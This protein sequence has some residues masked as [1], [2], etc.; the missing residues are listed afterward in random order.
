MRIYPAIRAQMG[1]WSYYMV[2]MKMR[3]IAQEVELAH[4]IYEDKT[5][6]EAIQRALSRTRAHKQIVGYLARRDDRFFSSIVVAAMGGNPKWNPLP[7]DATQVPAVL[8]ESKLLQESFGVLSFDEEPKYYALDGQHRVAAIKLLV[9]GGVGR[10]ANRLVAP[11]TFEND[12]LS[13]LV[14]SREDH[15][16]SDEEWMRRYRRMFS[17]L[18]RY[19]KP[20]DKDTNIIMDEDDLFAILTRRLITD[21]EFFRAPGRER[22]S[23]RVQMEGKNLRLRSPHFTSLQTLYEANRILLTT[24][25]RQKDGWYSDG[26]SIDQQVRPDEEFIDECYE[27]LDAYWTAI[28]KALPVLHSTPVEMRVHNLDGDKKLPDHLLFWPIGQELF[29]RLARGILDRAL[30]TGYVADS[31][32]DGPIEDPKQIAQIAGALELLKGLPWD[33]HKSP[34]RHLLLVPTNPP[35]DVEWRM[36][37]EDRKVA[38]DVAYRLLHW[39]AGLGN[40]SEDEVVSLHADWYKLLLHAPEGGQFDAEEMWKD[41]LAIK[42]NVSDTKATPEID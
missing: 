15:D 20:T 4:D 30:P 28:I 23:E 12:L 7:V 19:A 31:E 6:S 1:D 16:I 10:G 39:I 27:E 2:R 11:P 29:A 17:S 38:L 14:I 3:E 21:H 5:L 32:K 33:L 41:V 18:N 8:A 13:V 36:R 24:Y 9:A 34:W 25:A 40:L 26:T 42:S 37:S 35:A 22:E